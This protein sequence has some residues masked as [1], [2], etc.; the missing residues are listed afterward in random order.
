MLDADGYNLALGPFADRTSWA[1][2]AHLD[3]ALRKFR[4][5]RVVHVSVLTDEMK[6]CGFCDGEKAPARY[7]V[8]R[9]K[10]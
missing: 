6:P 10:I 2:R 4:P 5:A 8:W 7:L 1:C 9:S 3:A